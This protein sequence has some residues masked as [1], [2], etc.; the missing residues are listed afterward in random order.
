MRKQLC[1]LTKGILHIYTHLY[2]FFLLYP[3]FL[4]NTYNR[5]IKLNSWSIFIFETERFVLDVSCFFP[6][7]SELP[8]KYFPQCLCS[9]TVCFIHA[10]LEL[11]INCTVCLAYDES[12]RMHGI[13]TTI[14]LSCLRSRSQN[15]WHRATIWLSCLRSRSENAWHRDYNLTVA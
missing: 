6:F 15:A 2:I 12:H 10:W 7:F 14:W 5:F 11:D 13:G 1:L 4:L 8:I 9:N 3:M